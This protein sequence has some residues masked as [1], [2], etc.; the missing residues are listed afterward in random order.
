MND[1]RFSSLLIDDGGIAAIAAA[2]ARPDPSRLLLWHRL[3]A[4]RAPGDLAQRRSTMVEAHA[5]RT[6]AGVC[7]AASRW[8]S[9]LSGTEGTVL[10]PALE[11]AGVLFEAVCAA[12]ARGLN[13]V[14]WPVRAGPD[15]DHICTAV[16]MATGVGDLVAAALGWSDPVE[17]ELPLVDLDMTQ[18][19]DLADDV[20]VPDGLFWPCEHG[21]ETPCGGCTSCVQL[22][23]ALERQGLEAMWTA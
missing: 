14:I 8:S 18:V 11:V 5:R 21:G 12:R 17:I 9:E 22:R 1:D 15:P 10:D 7:I 2:L 23:R 3:G 16:D 13:H 20:G 19:V 6:G 4:G